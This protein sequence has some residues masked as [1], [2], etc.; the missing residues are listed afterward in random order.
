MTDFKK[1]SA[2]LLL[3]ALLSL[4]AAD[5]VAGRDNVSA[6][7]DEEIERSLRDFTAPIF[8]QAGLSSQYVRFVLL[9]KNELNAFVAGGMNIFINTGLILETKSADQLVGVLAHETGHIAHGDL[10]RSKMN[11]ENLSM[12]AMVATVLGIAIAAATGSGDAAMATTAAGQHAAE[13][14]LLTHSRI[15]E[16]AADQSAVQYMKGAGL[17]LDGL[18][19][20]LEKMESEELLPESQQTEYMRTHPLT[21][22]RISYMQGVVDQQRV[23]AT[24]P[25]GWPEQHARMKSKLMGFLFPDR[26]LQ[27]KSDTVAAKYGRAIAMFRKGKMTEALALLEPLIKA[28]PQNPYFL[29]LKGQILFENGKIEESLAPYSKAVQFAPRSGLIRASYAHALLESKADPKKRQAEAVK[30]LTL[31]LQTEPRE[32]R[33]HRMLAIAYGKQGQQGL[34]HLHLAEES[35]LQNK[36]DN[37][38]RESRLAGETLSKNSASWLRSTD[39]LALAQKKKKQKKD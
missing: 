18:L 23:K 19:A 27:D 1:I 39:I 9:D 4:G 12:E 3:A 35:L 13:R 25:A 5:A 21:Q 22:D 33:S 29:E 7:R 30:Q 31:A 32:S 6:I 28:E 16:T 11:L 17:P 26:A 20:F 24:L 14:A 36:L 38:I 2:A 34:S 15:Q 10:L 37:A 8:Q